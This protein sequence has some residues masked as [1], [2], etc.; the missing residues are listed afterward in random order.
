LLSKKDRDKIPETRKAELAVIVLDFYGV[1]D[2][3]D[4]L[5]QDAADMDY[6]YDI[7]LTC[8]PTFTTL[9]SRTAE[10]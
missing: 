2:L 7:Y 9:N 5:L 4:D 3:S 8:N 10:S 1:T 6:R